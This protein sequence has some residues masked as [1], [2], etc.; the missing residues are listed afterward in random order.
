MVSRNRRRV[1]NLTVA[2]LLLGLAAWI[3]PSYFSA[4]GYRRRLRAGLE[5]ALHRPVKFGALSFHL[6]PRPGFIIDN[7]EV[8]EDPEFGAEP[9]ARVD[10]I[11]CDFRWHSLWRS[12]MDFSRLHLDRPSFNIVLNSQGKWNVEKLLSQAGVSASRGGRAGS[13]SSSSGPQLDLDVSDARINFQ[14]GPNEKPFALTDVQAHLGV[15]PARHQVQFQI[16]ASP[17]RADLAI[18]TPGPVEVSGAW[19]PGTELGGP[20]DARLRTRGALLYD[21]VPV[22][23]GRNPQVYGVIDSDVHMT[24][25]LPNCIVEGNATL[26]QIHRWQELPPLDPMPFTFQFRAR[27]VRERERVEVEKLDASFADSHLHVSGTV[28][29]VRSNPRLDLVMSLER[30]RLEDV[31][32]AVR[33]LWP[34]T[35]SWNLKGRIDAMLAIQGPW[36]SRRYGGFVGIRRVSLGTPSGSFPL[37]DIAIRINSRGATLSPVQV[38]LA[39]RVELEALGAITPTKWGPR[40]ELQLAAKGVPLHNVVSFGRGFG[41][42][43]FQV[44]DGTGAATA[45]MHFSGSAW[46][47]SRPVLTARA[48]LRA[49]RLFLPGLT[50]PLNVP[51]ARLQL[52]GD[53]ISADP[54][55]AV[56]GTSVFHA[57]LR[58]QGAWVT[59]WNFDLRADSLRLDEGALW[60]DAL[61]L[62]Q[63]VPLLQH[64]PGLASFEARRQV[65]SQIF[66]KLNAQGRFATP[67][68]TYRGVMLKDF[69][70]N[71]EIAGRI[72]RMKTATFRA[73]GGRG[74]ATGS[75]D[76]TLSP[77]LL[78]TRASLTGASV[79][80]LTGSLAGPVHDL[81]GSVDGTGSFRARGLA[82]EDLAESL[83]GQMTLHLKDISFAGFDLLGT[84]AQQAHW[85]TLEAARGP[86]VSPSAILDME[87]RDRRFV[88]KSAALGISGIELRLDGAC[89]WTGALNLNVRT[90]L[91][92]LHRRWLPHE[93]DD[94][95]PPAGPVE[96]RLAG[97]MDHL[98]VNPQEVV[99]TEGR[100]RPGTRR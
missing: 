59:P 22:V 58:H 15:N 91:R 23:T 4:E 63:P 27:L 31:T 28:G 57:K 76:F 93:P 38:T 39:P 50:E 99:A 18:P 3:L 98:V 82:R 53:Q 95:P 25:S 69:Q 52:N 96:V 13:K 48:E 29:D 71:F 92:R 51:S 11:D 46:P 66:G 68:L 2:L 6:L 65:T 26:S 30:S 20:I 16:I 64:L 55:I 79:Q 45:L 86:V 77:P 85:G 81:N 36:K 5:Q 74:R 42:R 67:A 24:G 40:Y 12:R 14:I 8:A 19:T 1:R 83:T 100:R 94:L 62:R 43:A 37:S 72:I 10:H 7:A 87:V 34:N 44:I 70:G 17:V 84:L 90:D 89:S 73:S 88:L 9:F 78:S 80:G 33:R 21:W 75:A 54:V 32:G 41:I 49:A 35:S 61:G 47:L 97:S 60:F 56:L